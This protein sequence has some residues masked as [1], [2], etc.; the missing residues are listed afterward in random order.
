MVLLLLLL[1]LLLLFFF[2]A[3]ADVDHILWGNLR[4]GN[5][6]SRL[7][8]P[9]RNFNK[10]NIVSNKEIMFESSNLFIELTEEI[11]LKMNVYFFHLGSCG[12]VLGQ[13]PNSSR[14]VRRCCTSLFQ[15]KF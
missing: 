4:I 3:D 2:N 11:Y 12:C 10:K 14:F 15:Y 5:S 7:W 6:L 8:M 9:Y 13:G 1:L